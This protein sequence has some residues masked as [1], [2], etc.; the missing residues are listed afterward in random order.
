MFVHEPSVTPFLTDLFLCCCVNAQ[1]PGSKPKALEF[2]LFVSHFFPGSH[3]FHSYPPPKLLGHIKLKAVLREKF[4]FPSV[5]IKK[6][7]KKIT[8]N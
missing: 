6:I 3:S 4:I 1:M 5:F 8:N 2:A 7:N